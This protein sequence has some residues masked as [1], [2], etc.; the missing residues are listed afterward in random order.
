MASPRAQRSS[1]VGEAT[2]V[3]SIFSSFL[4]FRQQQL[5]QTLANLLQ[6]GVA[7][8]SNNT[9]KALNSITWK[10]PQFFS[11]TVNPSTKL[12]IVTENVSVFF[13]QSV[14]YFSPQVDDTE[15][16][17]KDL[18][19]PSR[20]RSSSQVKNEWSLSHIPFWWYL[21]IDYCIFAGVTVSSRLA[22]PTSCKE[23]KL[24]PS[25]IFNN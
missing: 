13:F 12:E 23:Q 2:I 3:V 5:L 18:T 25:R 8:R 4:Y 20:K 22:S 10:L 17:S 7:Q 1:G 9:F 15:G 21:Q 24:H 19:K 11:D 16:P 14:Q 6:K